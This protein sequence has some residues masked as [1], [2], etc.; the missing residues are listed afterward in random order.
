MPLDLNSAMDLMTIPIT[1][2]EHPKGFWGLGKGLM[3]IAHVFPLITAAEQRIPSVTRDLNHLPPP[4]MK[5]VFTL[6]MVNALGL[7]GSTGF[8]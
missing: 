4:H 7:G 3:T 1:L 6:Y 8:G 2:G 5:D